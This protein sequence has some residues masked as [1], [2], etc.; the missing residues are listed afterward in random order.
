MYGRERLYVLF[1]FR[2][3][4]QFVNPATNPFPGNHPV[5]KMNY[6]WPRFLAQEA[7]KEKKT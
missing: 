5:L 2:Q 7:G 4:L 6:F 3:T 1:S